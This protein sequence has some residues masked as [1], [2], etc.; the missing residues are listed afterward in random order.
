MRL[1]DGRASEASAALCAGFARLA[2][3]PGELVATQIVLTGDDEITKLPFAFA[4]VPA[5]AAEG[6]KGFEPIAG[7]RVGAVTVVGLRLSLLVEEHLTRLTGTRVV[8]ETAARRTAVEDA[9]VAQAQPP[10]T[11]V[12]AVTFFAAVAPAV[13]R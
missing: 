2:A 13:S 12:V 5:S 9:G 6:V 4:I 8:R 3:E 7:A 10:G 1:A 11:L